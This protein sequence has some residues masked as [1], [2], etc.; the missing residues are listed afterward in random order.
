MLEIQNTF[1]I[2]KVELTLKIS[3]TKLIIEFEYNYAVCSIVLDVMFI[4]KF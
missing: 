3:S 1:K 4:H 2:G